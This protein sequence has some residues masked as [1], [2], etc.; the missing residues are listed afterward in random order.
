MQ[1][2]RSRCCP[3]RFTAHTSRGR[4]QPE[5]L[6]RLERRPVERLSQQGRAKTSIAHQ[7]THRIT[8]KVN[9]MSL[10]VEFARGTVAVMAK[11]NNPEL[12]FNLRSALASGRPG[13]GFRARRSLR[14]EGR[15]RPGR[16][17]PLWTGQ[18]RV[19]PRSRRVAPQVLAGITKDPLRETRKSRAQRSNER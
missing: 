10:L 7:L 16:D 19:R 6:G 17:R 3:L 8:R 18:V 11:M 15:F 4:R 2:A 12:I 1:E 5:F 9:F 14:T 13:A